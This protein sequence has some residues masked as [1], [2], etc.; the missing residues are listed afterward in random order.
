[1]NLVTRIIQTLLVEQGIVDYLLAVYLPDGGAKSK[2]HDADVIEAAASGGLWKRSKAGKRYQESLD[3]IV[4]ALPI[5]L[6]WWLAD[7]RRCR[8]SL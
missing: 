1:M 8:Y 2:T 6:V 7:T 3:Q 5:P 4:P